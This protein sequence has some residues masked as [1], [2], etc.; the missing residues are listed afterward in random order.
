MTNYSI[1]MFAAGP[2]RK[3]IN[4]QQLLCTTPMK[5]LHNE[6][7]SLY[8][9]LFMDKKRDRYFRHPRLLLSFSFF[10]TFSEHII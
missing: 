3:H 9:D 10:C 5:V 2:C 6:S 1:A 7:S 4:S 8:Y